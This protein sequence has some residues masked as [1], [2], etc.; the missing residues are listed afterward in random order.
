MH[1]SKQGTGCSADE[2]PTADVCNRYRQSEFADH[3][4]DEVFV[5]DRGGE[6]K[7]EGNAERN[8]GLEQADKKRDGGARAEGGDRTEERGDK[9]PPKTATAHPCL[10][11]LLWQPGTDKADHKDHH[12]KQEKDL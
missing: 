7:G 6:E 12:G 9:I 1:L 8:S 11:S 2:E 4:D 10:E 5:D 3:E